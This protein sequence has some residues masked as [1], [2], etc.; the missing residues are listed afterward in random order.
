M[1]LGTG[2]SGRG[3]I[4]WAWRLG[5]GFG[6][7]SSPRRYLF[8]GR[9]ST[10]GRARLVFQKANRYWIGTPVLNLVIDGIDLGLIGNRR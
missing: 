3:S 9:A 4:G 8:Y 1:G 7:S 10:L 6:I 5:I 2:F